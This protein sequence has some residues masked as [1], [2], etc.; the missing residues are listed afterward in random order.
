MPGELARVGDHPIT[1]DVEFDLWKGTYR[2]KEV[3]IVSVKL[4]VE[5][6]E[7]RKIRTNIAC[8]HRVCS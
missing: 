5:N 1:V 8:L 4:P 6:H 2:G 3:Y 7:S